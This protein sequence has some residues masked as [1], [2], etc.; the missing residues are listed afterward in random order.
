VLPES[1][2]RSS[3]ETIFPG[4][5]LPQPRAL[6]RGCEHI[7]VN[8]QGRSHHHTPHHDALTLARPSR[9]HLGHAT[10]APCCSFEAV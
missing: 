1:A 2:W 5:D 7:V 8:V 3:S 9:G 6:L 10:S 4:G